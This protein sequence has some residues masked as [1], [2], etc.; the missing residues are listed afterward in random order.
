MRR[1]EKC[2]D[3]PLDNYRQKNGELMNSL[4]NTMSRNMQSITIHEG[5]L[6]LLVVLVMIVQTNEELMNEK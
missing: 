6:C 5:G 3:S 2:I 4:L 1:K